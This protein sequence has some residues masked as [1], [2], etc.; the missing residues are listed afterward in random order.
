MAIH[1]WMLF[2][3]AFLAEI[4]MFF[5]KKIASLAEQN[6][7]KDKNVKKKWKMKQNV[8]RNELKR[9]KG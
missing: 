1:F 8:W 2:K 9:M 5:L 6:R 4:P 7:G 3:T